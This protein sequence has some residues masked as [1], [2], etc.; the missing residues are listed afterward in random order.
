MRKF[1]KKL[2]QKTAFLVLFCFFSCIVFREFVPL[3]EPPAFLFLPSVPPQAAVASEEFETPEPV[4]PTEDLFLPA[5]GHTLIYYNQHDPRW[6]AKNYGPHNTISSY[7]CGPTVLSILVSSLTDSAVP[8]GQMAAWCYQNGFFSQNSGSY[9][10]IIPEGAAAWGLDSKS[11]TDLSYKAILEELYAGRIVVMLMGSGHFT[12][13]GHFIIIRSVTL[14]GQLLIADPNSLENT[15]IPWDYDTI[16]SELKH[17]YDAGGPAWSVGI[18]SAPLDDAS[19]PEAPAGLS[20]G[21]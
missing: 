6:A 10:S 13:S 11:L 8:P 17:T 9:H 16:V 19:A 12:S 14:E 1:P 4:S 21:T 20:D 3:F 5:A 2:L 18:P 7:G 15:Q